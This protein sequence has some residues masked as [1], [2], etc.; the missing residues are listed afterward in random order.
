MRIRVA[1]NVKIVRPV[2]HLRIPVGAGDK[3]PHPVVLA[4]GLPVQ[5]NVV[6]R[7][8]LDGTHRRIVAQALLRRPHRPTLGIRLQ[9]RPLVRVLRKGQRAVANQV[10]GSFVP[11]REQQHHIVDGHIPVENAV[12]LALR[13]HRN[14]VV[15]GFP[16]LNGS[17]P[18]RH[19][20]SNVI[21]Q[22]L[23]RPRQRRHPVGP[24]PVEEPQVLRQL[25]QLGPVAVRYAQHPRDDQ[26]R[27]RRGQVGHHIH[28]PLLRHRVQ[29]LVNGRLHQRAPHLHRLGRE[30][31]VHH[32]PHIHMVGPRN[33]RVVPLL[34]VL[35]EP[36]NLPLL[37]EVVDFHV[38]LVNRRVRRAHIPRVH[39]GRK[40]LRV[41]GHPDQ[42][43]PR[44]NHPDLKL[45]V[46]IHRL[47]LP[48]PVVE[49]IGLVDGL[50]RKRV[51][52]E[53]A[54]HWR[55]PPVRVDSSRT[56]RRRPRPP[57]AMPALYPMHP[58]NANPKR[59]F[60]ISPRLPATT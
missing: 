45:L 54:N 33:L 47:E 2:E 30:V 15:V 37:D 49:L 53:S 8:P 52:V 21:L 23:H 1:F 6:H 42:M 38:I 17:H 3:P 31:P 4:D 26:Q 14:Q 10:D 36:G 50:Q 11:G 5:L 56:G 13:H 55:Q 40:R 41:P 57:C 59:P 60:G 46:V 18:L 25:P 24:L 29:Q 39:A 32:P 43:L 48:Q 12:H 9:N 51:V 28:A 7:N 35:N 22:V 27:Q 58:P 34:V 44:G 16:L 20:R 19:Q